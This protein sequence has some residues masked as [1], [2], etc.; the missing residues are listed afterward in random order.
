MSGRSGSCPEARLVSGGS[1]GWGHTNAYSEEV[2]VTRESTA[3]RSDDLFCP[4]LL[5]FVP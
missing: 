4:A 3:A 2:E 1:D 5:L